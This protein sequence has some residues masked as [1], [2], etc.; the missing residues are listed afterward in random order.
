MLSILA[1]GIGRLGRPKAN[2]LSGRVGILLL[3]ITTVKVLR[4]KLFLPTGKEE[5]KNA[6]ECLINFCPS[7]LSILPMGAQIE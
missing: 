5:G 3:E 7:I 4:S 2:R 6:N 1:I